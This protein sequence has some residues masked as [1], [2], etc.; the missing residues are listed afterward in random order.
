MANRY[1]W[2]KSAFIF[3]IALFTF[4]SLSINEV[5]AS[6]NTTVAITNSDGN[7]LQFTADSH[8]LS[9]EPDKPCFASMDQALSTQF[10]GTQVAMPK[11]DTNAS[12]KGTATQDIS[13]VHQ[14]LQTSF[15]SVVGHNNPTYVIRKTA[16]SYRGCNVRQHLSMDFSVSGVTI[17]SGNS[18]WKLRL[19]K[20]GYG[21]NMH[22]APLA[23][24][25]VTANRVEYSYIGIVEWYINGPLGLEQGFTIN[26]RPAD[27]KE[28]GPLTLEL[29]SSGDLTPK[30]DGAGSGL[31]LTG[32]NGAKILRYS[33][34]SAVDAKGR[35]L[36]AWME[37]DGLRLLVRVDDSEAQYP[38]VVD[39]LIQTE[40]LTASDGA[41]GDGFG[42]AAAVSGDGSTALI[43]APGK[44]SDK[45]VA[46]V[47]AFNGTSWV[48][49]Q[50][51]TASDGLAGD[52]FGYSTAL[53][54]DGNTALIAA[55]G[56]YAGKGAVYV[57]TRS[58]TTWSQKQ[59]LLA[60]DG[61]AGDYFGY[62]L[63][64]NG[65]GSTALIC[66]PKNNANNNVAQGA[67]YVFALSGSTWV[68][69]QKLTDPDNVKGNSFASSVALSGDGNTA[70]INTYND[71]TKG[72][73]VYV[74]AL[75]GMTF[76][77]QQELSPPQG[78]PDSAGPD[79]GASLAISSNG[80]TALT[81][82]SLTDSTQ[83]FTEVFDPG[84]T[85]VYTRSGGTWSLQQELT[86]SDGTKLDGFGD[87]LAISGDGNTALI[88]APGKNSDMGAAYV[89]TLSGGTWSQQQEL[90]ASDG[91][92]NDGFGL[93]TALN[94]N[95]TTAL[96]SAAAKN[97]EQGAVYV[98]G[99]SLWTGNIINVANIDNVSD[100]F[101]I[102]M[103]LKQNGTPSTNQCSS[104]LKVVDPSSNRTAIQQSCVFL[105]GGTGRHQITLQITGDTTQPNR[106][107]RY[108]DN[109]SFYLCA[110]QGSSAW[111][112]SSCSQISSMPT[113]FAVYG[114]TFDIGKHAW[115]FAN[116][117]YANPPVGLSNS[118]YLTLANNIW[119]AAKAIESYVNENN[120][121]GIWNNVY[122]AHGLV[123]T[124]S[125]TYGG[126]GF[127][128]NIPN[129]T[130]SI[131]LG[132]CYGLANAAIA[133]FTHQYDY[134]SWGTGVFTYADWITDI[135]NRWADYYKADSPFNVPDDN[136]FMSSQLNNP[137]TVWTID[138][139]KKIMYYFVAQPSYAGQNW[140]GRDQF[141]DLDSSTEPSFINIL[142][143]GSPV[144]FLPQAGAHQN[145]VPQY[146]IWNGHRN[147]MTWENAA[148]LGTIP[149]SYGPYMS[150]YIDNTSLYETTQH[151]P[152]QITSNTT[153]I[154]I[155]GGDAWNFGFMSSGCG[156]SQNI[157]NQWTVPWSTCTSSSQAQLQP[158]DNTNQTTDYPYPDHIQVLVIGAQVNSVY[159]QTASSPVTLIPNG[160]IV[161]GQA[162]QSVS[163]NGLFTSLYLPVSDTYQ[164]QATKYAGFAGLEVFVTIPNTDGKAQQL[165]YENLG[166][167]VADA[168]QITFTVGL[169]NTNTGI[170]RTIANDVYNPDYNAP[171][172]TVLSP[173]TNLNAVVN[174]GGTGVALSWTNT[175][176]PLLASVLVIRKAGSA[177]S[178][179]TDGTT[180]YS[181]TG[182]SAA[183]TVTANTVYY[184]AAYS[185]DGSGNLSTP[186][187]IQ[188]NT[189]LESIYG[190][191]LT[192]GGG[193][194]NASVQLLDSN[195]NVIGVTAST[196][197]G[198]YAMS[199]IAN[200]SYTLTVSHPTAVI[201]SPS[202]VAVTLSGSSQ[203][204]DFTATNQ[205][206]L[207]LL[208]NSLSVTVGDTVSIPW[209][210][211]NIG[212]NE[213]VNIS[214]LR[215]SVWETIAS[216]VPIT[217]GVISWTV[218][219]PEVSSAT[220]E[221]S[222][223][224]Y[225]TVNAQYTL[226]IAPS[227]NFI[228]TPTSGPAPLAVS[229]VDESSSA[230][231][232][233][234]NF[235]D[236][237]TSTVQNPLHMYTNS[238][239]Y[240]VSETVT[241]TSGQVVTTK[242][243]YI[244]VSGTCSSLPVTIADTNAYYA[245]L[246]SA[247]SVV[248]AGQTLLV[249]EMNITESP[250]TTQD[251]SI[252]L[253]GGYGCDFSMNPGF[254]TVHGTLTISQGTVTIDN[255]L[256]Q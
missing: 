203:E 187:I 237:T 60:S 136:I 63:A 238:G 96:I 229:F 162:V 62:V 186:T 44:N 77:L 210:Y 48:L 117:Q 256:I 196:P 49:Q 153:G 65:N 46:Y 137:D 155:A 71:A 150:I 100:T 145:A 23:E 178:S 224:D 70:L 79:F 139:A 197:N 34:L 123:L 7:M 254:T 199:N 138:S 129:N 255:I 242:N 75:S 64:L 250:T 125:N 107:A 6:Q 173:P 198:S 42:Y 205:E 112:L 143:G 97:S 152:Y 232:W 83:N 159:D 33:G 11:D 188:L 172:T 15:S 110:N 38:V 148:P 156:D 18:Q 14:A 98:Y 151:F 207:F 147:I 182:Q 219:G 133:S 175:N 73:G 134:D 185:M 124:H 251:V 114:T 141:T 108:I 31:I 43:G 228:G 227:Y 177:P 52:G 76:T 80:N 87:G 22:A 245:S 189:G 113:D 37:L 66:A 179:S 212:N 118:G 149:S 19:N 157:Y 92:A 194:S 214:L 47:F 1:K 58:G 248:G 170:S 9:F 181:G 74:Y 253:S 104:L 249:Q 132:L 168:T 206:T 192:S 223:A 59:E 85:Y 101:T 94:D 54:N 218:T 146:I 174:N 211:R 244:I 50:E 68:Q 69:Q 53:S 39:P 122:Q 109:A 21:N 20:I 115:Q 105:D 226:T 30:L 165:N 160:D 201:N 164:I 84:I 35:Q 200:G 183:D 4:S 209:A 28:G 140:V 241:G 234:W 13:R 78:D 225:S 161:A 163:S 41:A 12:A 81:S 217:N 5:I 86:A 93:I 184:Y 195:N 127:I 169:G 2:S 10:T 239:T 17:R 246:G 103:D 126:L 233:L 89:F 236:G 57:F 25:N 171:L 231:A 158:Q 55:S 16:E 3:I 167:A 240:T 8:I 243:N 29:S 36:H 208:F 67:A 119:Y 142:K 190:T 102:W 180:V 222:L 26:R 131:S 220:L 116:E 72:P 204:V 91:A 56:K 120:R 128:P 45:G 111:D 235:G 121:S 176:N 252:T 40:E 154:R 135:A 213:T 95:G 61:T 32:H 27:K 106:T 88:G 202:S 230:T 51:L 130:L 144:S 90:T 215:N 191:I 24:P 216:G 221:I 193:L 99:G 166:T 247:L 82:S